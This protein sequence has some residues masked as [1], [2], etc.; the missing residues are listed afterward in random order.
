MYSLSR[1]NSTIPLSEHTK[2]PNFLVARHL[3]KLLQQMTNA[4]QNLSSKQIVLLCNLTGNNTVW[5]AK[6]AVKGLSFKDV[7]YTWILTIVAGMP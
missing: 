3:D 5:I 2:S 4:L 1:E 6:D 7:T